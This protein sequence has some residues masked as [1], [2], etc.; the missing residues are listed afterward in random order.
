MFKS[1]QR[2]KVEAV[3]KVVAIL[4]AIA[5]VAFLLIPLLSA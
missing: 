5:M 2:K 3:Y 1:N 4:I